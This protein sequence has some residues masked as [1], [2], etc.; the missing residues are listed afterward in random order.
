MFW[1]W[2]FFALAISGCSYGEVVTL[3]GA[4]IDR[5]ITENGVVMIKYFDPACGYC[6]QMEK[7]YEQVAKSMEGLAFFAE[8]DVM[9]NRDVAV[10]VGIKGT[11]T[12]MLYENGQFKQA[13]KGN[14]ERD[15]ILDFMV[16]NM[17]LKARVLETEAEVE[18][19][20]K[21]SKAMRV[22]MVKSVESKAQ[23]TF[24]ELV[25]EVHAF[26]PLAVRFATV[27]KT[28]TLK[29]F[30]DDDITEGEQPTHTMLS[31]LLL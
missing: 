2:F 11:P 22:I 27:E 14:R 9:K 30:V 26:N 1:A 23:G 5:F 12:L 20:I 13:Y 4:T 25:E 7:A 16:H 17:D 24:D 10:R 18:S 19:F 8:L 3:S 28:E 29:Q 6:Q 21:S 15:D 31:P